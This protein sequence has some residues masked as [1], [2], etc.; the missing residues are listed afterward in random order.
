MR[1]TFHINMYTY[2]KFDKRVSHFSNRLESN[3]HTLNTNNN[4]KIL[5][6]DNSNKRLLNMEALKIRKLKTNSHKTILIQ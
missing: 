4:F 5:H 3:N 6:Q 2:R 1:W